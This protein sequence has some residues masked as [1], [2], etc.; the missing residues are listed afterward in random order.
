[1]PWSRHTWCAALAAG[2]LLTAAIPEARAESAA[3]PASPH[4]DVA[5]ARPPPRRRAL[6]DS[7]LRSGV[8][9]TD[10]SPGRF[11]V[12]SGV[13]ATDLS[14]Q[15]YRTRTR[16][17]RDEWFQEPEPKTLLRLGIDGQSAR[18]GGGLDARFALEEE[19]WGIATRLGV[20]GLNESSGTGR[21]EVRTLVDAH[22]TYAM[23]YTERARLR[24]EL[25]LASVRFPE[26]TFVGP[27]VAMSFERCLVGSLDLEGR[28]QWMPLPGVQLDGQIG[29]ALHLGALVV[30]A[31]WR[32][33]L[34][35]DRGLVTGVIHVS[36]IGGPFSG[37]GLSF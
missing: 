20:L 13:D 26:V 15:H 11:R 12:R 10:L 30:R 22:V 23:A 3:E 31:G 19:R 27:S 37:V 28:L 21:R 1:M 32:G 7:R 2:C 4:G 29:F 17:P 6:L 24:L 34:S 18:Q 14:Y 5:P 9:A 35:D 16:P 25:G 36:G 8:D 33:L